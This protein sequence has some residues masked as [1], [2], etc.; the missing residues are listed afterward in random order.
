[1]KSNQQIA[2]NIA[3]N[4]RRLLGDKGWSQRELSR[5]TG[6][7]HMSVVNVLTAEHTPS[8]GLLARIAEAFGVKSDDLLSDP[9]T[10][11]NSRRSA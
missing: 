6:D 1:M 10:K 4:I 7:P 11:K 2:A 9:P 8:A 5:R 3:A